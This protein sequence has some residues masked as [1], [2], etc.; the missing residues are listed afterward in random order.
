MGLFKKDTAVLSK[1][2]KK[3]RTIFVI[4][5]ILVLFA[6]F[7]LNLFVGLGK[8]MRPV[9]FFSGGKNIIYSIRAVSYTHLDVYKRQLFCRI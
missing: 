6:I 3:I 5:C 9:I 1:T 4:G 2:D 8:S 7:V